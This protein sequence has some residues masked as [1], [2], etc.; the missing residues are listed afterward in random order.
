M[1]NEESPYAVCTEIAE[2]IIREHRGTIEILH[3]A[4]DMDGFVCA[5]YETDGV[6]HYQAFVFRNDAETS[7]PVEIIYDGGYETT[8]KHWY[9][10]ANFRSRALWGDYF[11]EVYG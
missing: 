2:S 5:V 6:R 11:D 9:M 3:I 10:G 4:N 1:Q 7:D 8:E